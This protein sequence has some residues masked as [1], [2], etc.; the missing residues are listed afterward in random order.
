LKAEFGLGSAAWR[1]RAY[2]RTFEA[3]FAALE[4]RR[5]ADPAFTVGDAAGTLRHLYVKEG[6]DDGSG[7]MLQDAV[8]AAT[9]AAHEQFISIWKAES[10]S[11]VGPDRSTP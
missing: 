4:A 11:T 9:I 2:E 1:D 3:V 10:A 7:G 6:N 8:L 5:K